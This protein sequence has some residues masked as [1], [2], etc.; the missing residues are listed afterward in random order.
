M[1]RIVFVFIVMVSAVCY[2]QEPL[3]KSEQCDST[4]LNKEA[5]IIKEGG[6]GTSS[7]YTEIYMVVTDSIVYRF[8]LKFRSSDSSF[9]KKV[10]MEPYSRR[11]YDQMQAANERA[12]RTQEQRRK[13]TI[14][15]ING[16]RSSPEVWLQFQ[17]LEALDK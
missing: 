6:Y 15:F 3:G 9:I 8:G 4:L 1:K 10:P 16:Y 11:F 5:C 7:T 12:K 14:E 2:C 13:E 17:I